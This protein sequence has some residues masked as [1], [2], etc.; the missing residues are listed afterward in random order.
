MQPNSYIEYVKTK[1]PRMWASLEGAAKE[2][3]IFIDEKN[4][5]IT[6]TNRLL[7]TYPALHEI[8]NYLVGEWKAEQA[9]TIGFDHIKSLLEAQ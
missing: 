2:G 7:L 6:A 1:E 4:D 9:K 5:A 8:I 3:L